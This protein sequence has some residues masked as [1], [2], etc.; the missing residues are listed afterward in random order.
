M[1]DNEKIVVF[2]W[3]SDGSGIPYALGIFS[4]QASAEHFVNVT[5]PLSPGMRFLIS[6]PV[7][8]F[9]IK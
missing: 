8:E 2:A 1:T 5:E 6:S 9:S 3:Y 7:R 4:D